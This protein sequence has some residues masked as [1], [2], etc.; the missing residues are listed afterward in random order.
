MEAILSEITTQCG[1]AT[2]Y[3]ITPTGNREEQYLEAAS[4][5]AMLEPGEMDVDE[6]AGEVVG[7]H[8]AGVVQ[9]VTMNVAGVCDALCPAAT[10]MED[11]LTKLLADE[12]P[13]VL[14]FQEV[15]DEMYRERATR[16][17]IFDTE[18]LC[19]PEPWAMVPPHPRLPQA[20]S[21]AF[22]LPTK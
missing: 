22:P 5:R 17:L 21:L 15:T 3:R 16:S 20:G 4:R 1:R 18:P 8:A 2:L 14:C 10:R 9:L 11:I 6:V 19:G 7:A 13:D 12:K